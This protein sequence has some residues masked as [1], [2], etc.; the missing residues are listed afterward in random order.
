[1]WDTLTN[2]DVVKGAHNTSNETNGN[3]ILKHPHGPPDLLASTPITDRLHRTVDFTIP[4]SPS[5][6]SKR[7][8]I[9]KS[10]LADPLFKHPAA[11]STVRG[12]TRLDNLSPVEVSTEVSETHDHVAFLVDQNN[13]AR[14]EKLTF[15]PYLPITFTTSEGRTKTITALI[16]TASTS[17][18]VT[19]SLNNFLPT[20][21]RGLA[22]CKIDTIVGSRDSKLEAVSLDLIPHKNILQD[23]TKSEHSETPSINFDCLVVNRIA[24][25]SH[26]FPHNLSK[27]LPQNLNYVNVNK[28]KSCDVDL[29][30]GMG[31]LM[32]V[33]NKIHKIPGFPKLGLCKVS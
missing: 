6:E 4:S 33:V 14:N 3:G 17:S 30:I 22:F 29:L 2:Q 5:T 1:M 7:T 20:K 8:A 15:L 28:D 24:G 21:T 26:N 9:S 27:V 16:D 12:E 10:T 32:Q 11:R 13:W 25:V 19:V 18:F 23:E 31:D